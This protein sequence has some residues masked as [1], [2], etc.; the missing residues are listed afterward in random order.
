MR[1]MGLLGPILEIPPSK[2]DD[3]S[4]SRPGQLHFCYKFDKI[5]K[6]RFSGMVGG[7]HL[8]AGKKLA[9]SSFRS[10]RRYSSLWPC[11]D[12]LREL[13]PTVEPQW[14]SVRIVMLWR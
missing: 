4:T 13:W 8:D 6:I 10:D 5:L 12:T 11:A 1:A 7:L 3:I 9:A 2:K 14:P